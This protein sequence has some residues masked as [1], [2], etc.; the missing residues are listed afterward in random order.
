MRILVI[1]DSHG[2][3]SSL[4]MAVERQRDAAMI[5]HLGDGEDDP[6]ACDARSR[7]AHLKCV[8]VRGNCDFGST[9]PLTAVVFADGKKIYCSHGHKEGVKYGDYALKQA[10]RGQNADIVLYGHTHL[11]VNYY[12]DG[13]YIFNPGSL[14]SGEY[15]VIDIT[16]AGIVCVNMKLP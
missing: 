2:D 12:E 8:R 6:A 3:I 16:K 10:A 14:R 1:S 7:T 5:I 15:G 9:A 4:R 11:P 13:L